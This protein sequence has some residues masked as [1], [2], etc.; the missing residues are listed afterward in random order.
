MKKYYI[1]LIVLLFS[2]CT[3]YSQDEQWY[4]K[5]QKNIKVH[6]I[7]T[8]IG[9]IKTLVVLPEMLNEDTKM[10]VYLHGDAPFNKPEGQYYM[11]KG[12]SETK[13]YISVAI[14]RPGY[15]DHCGDKSDGE[16]GRTMGDNYTKE[17]VESVATIITELNKEYK[18]SALVLMG[19]SGG[20]AL[21]LLLLS[22][23]HNLVD[24]AFVFSCPCNLPSW[25]NHMYEFQSDASWLED[26][27]GLSPLDY[28]N[29]LDPQIPITFIVGA[30]DT[31]APPSM[32]LEFVKAAE[33]H[34][35]ITVETWKE[36]DH[37]S[38]LFRDG[39]RRILKLLN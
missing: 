28:A 37:N 10:L 19:H 12:I 36:H 15:E 11:A 4:C 29:N 8:D 32:T 16:R 7:N 34:K 3:S 9:K 2:S 23:H 39:F 38:L 25:R 22:M 30:N 31:I 17:V 18:P 6:W 14:L 21:S 20:A 1:H 5:E 13:N 35:S 33:Q 24:E 27:P 26:M